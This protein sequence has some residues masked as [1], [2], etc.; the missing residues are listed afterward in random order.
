MVVGIIH[1][2]SMVVGIIH[3]ESMVVGI[4]HHESMDPRS[5]VLDYVL[6]QLASYTYLLF[7]T[8][9]ILLTLIDLETEICLQLLF[10]IMLPFS[11]F[12]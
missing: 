7:D 5:M 4:I 6:Y 3:H 11:E 8:T 9:Y 10:F 1:H 2:E 12:V